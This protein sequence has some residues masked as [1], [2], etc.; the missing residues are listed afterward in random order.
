MSS[1]VLNLLQA[2]DVIF[3]RAVVIVTASLVS[4]HSW[5][6]TKHDIIG[7]YMEAMTSVVVLPCAM[8]CSVA[9]SSMR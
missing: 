5:L 8:R 3:T 2:V 4:Y 7:P 9:E 1:V 6:G